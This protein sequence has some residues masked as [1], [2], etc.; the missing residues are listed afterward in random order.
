MVGGALWRRR[1]LLWALPLLLLDQASKHWA[2]A[3]LADGESRSILAPYLQLTLVENQGTVFGLLRGWGDFFTVLALVVV[4]GL[5]WFQPRLA[6]KAPA[7]L[8]LILIIAGALGNALD[9]L[10]HGYVVDF[11]HVEW[12]GVF[13]NVSNFSDHALVLGALLLG[14]LGALE[15]RAR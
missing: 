3:E 6:R 4:A 10:Q 15:E 9:R 7:Q 2:L 13:A 14:L 1:V 5:I 8:G 11:V 12:P